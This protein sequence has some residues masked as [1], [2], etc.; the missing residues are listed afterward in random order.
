MVAAP[1]FLLGLIAAAGLGFLAGWRAGRPSP[2]DRAAQRA[3]V[4]HAIGQALTLV[5][6]ERL[7]TVNAALDEAL[8]VTS[9][10]LGDTLAVGAS[11]LGRERQA[12]AAQTELVS[13]ELRRLTGLVSQLQNERASQAGQLTTRLDHAIEATTALAD[14]TRQLQRAL[15]S[16][17]ARGQWGERMADDVLR[18]AGF[19]EGVNYQRQQKLASGRV[20]DYS[21]P[22]PKGHV[23]HMDVKFPIDNYLVWLDAPTRPARA[24]A[25]KAFRRD[26][27]QRVK[28]LAGRAYVDADTTV[29]YMLAFVPNESVYGFLHEHDPKLLDDA[30]GQK[31][32][33]CSPTTLFA[34]LAV[35]RQAV[36]SFLMDQRSTEILGA[37]GALR[38]QWDRWQEPLN[39]MERGLE[40]ARKA[41]EDLAGPRTRQFE[42]QLEKLETVRDRHLGEEMAVD[43]STATA[44]SPEHTATA[45]SPE[46]TA[47]ARSSEHTDPDPGG[48]R[49]AV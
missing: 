39:K 18:A 14:T 24:R 5:R 2:A 42:R 3:E 19:V 15:A 6:L 12:M 27:R 31:V 41:F 13:T 46:H 37:V 33:L 10:K 25:A 30:L 29:D 11:E 22:L 49:R 1:V 26:V 20:P 35:I 38:A 8:A 44:R 45:R 32:V 16:P 40:S 28:E 17:G 36:D 23:V 34:V 48:L 43:L 47:T 21:F 4:D 7:E 9:S